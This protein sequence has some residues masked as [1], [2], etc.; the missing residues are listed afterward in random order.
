MKAAPG[1]DCAGTDRPRFR[2][3]GDLLGSFSTDLKK[4]SFNN[5]NDCA[6][7]LY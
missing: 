4:A 1:S 5:R 2:H 6:R 7:Q 3:F